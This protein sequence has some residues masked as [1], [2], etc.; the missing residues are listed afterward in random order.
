MS[1]GS[2]VLIHP[3]CVLCGEV[4]LFLR[5]LCDQIGK[6]VRKWRQRTSQRPYIIDIIA[7]EDEHEVLLMRALSSKLLLVSQTIHFSIN[8]E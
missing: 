5:R 6:N 2:V 4:E 3:I 7:D 8:D 1:V